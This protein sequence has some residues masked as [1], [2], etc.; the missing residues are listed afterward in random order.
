MSNTAQ[1]QTSARSLGAV[2]SLPSFLHGLA[3]GATVLA[4]IFVWMMIRANDTL[5]REQAK[6]PSKTAVIERVEVKAIVPEPVAQET[7][8]PGEP[9]KALPRAP[10]QGLFETRPE[11]QL[12][13]ANLRT[14][15][16]PFEAYKRPVTLVP[17]RPSIG[18]LFVGAGLSESLTEGILED[19][20]EDVSLSVSPYATGPGVWM[21]KIRAA[22][23]EVWLSLPL[24][25]DT[26]PDSDP[27]PNTLLNGV[28]IEQNQGRLFHILASGSGYVGLISMG[29]HAIKEADANMGPIIL[30]IFG[31][32]LAFV[33]GRTDR[34][35]FGTTL[36]ASES[37]PHAQ[38]NAWI[39][40]DVGPQEIQA[41]LGDAE[42]YAQ[43]KGQTIIFAY[44]AP[45][46]I[47]AVAAWSK[48]LEERGLQLAPLSALVTQ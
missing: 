38:T 6:L 7:I 41:L 43:L 31:R 25:N 1:E 24:Q 14:G 9:S 34:P 10:I 8:V 13:V 33:D 36:I 29:D 4:L 47:Q 42:R 30:Q 37:Y 27:G 19:L 18:V 3:G 48:T 40:E 26:Y 11:G 32:G 20:P 23:H 28:S 12:P 44:P 45:A 2:F 17:G 22:G 46:A 5:Q 15:L 21:D 35:F 16:T 39:G